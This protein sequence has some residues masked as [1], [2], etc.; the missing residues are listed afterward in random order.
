MSSDFGNGETPTGII[1]VLPAALA[2]KIA[3]GEVVQR[4]ASA[5]KELMEN[6]VD[7]GARKIRVVI[8][9]AGSSLV[10]VI[11]DG[12]GM[13][14][15]DGEM[16]FMRHATS[17][18]SSIEDL[19]RIHTLGFRGEALASIASVAQVELKTRRIDDE[20]G[21]CFRTSGGEELER[22]PCASPP[23]TS[24]A[25]RNLFFN[26]P[27]RRNFLKRPATEFKHIVEVFQYIALSKPSIGFSLTHDDRE[28]YDFT[29]AK[30]SDAFDPL[31]ER[32]AQVIGTMDM[33]GLVPVKTRT[34]YVSVSGYVGKPE[35][36]RKVRGEQ[37][38]YVNG[39]YVKHRGLLHAVSSAYG[40][41]LPKGSYPFFVLK[42]EMDPRHAD[43]NV[44]PTK[45]EVKF[46]DESGIYGF[47]RGSVN[48]A[49]GSADLRPDISFGGQDRMVER[50]Y[51]TARSTGSR[52]KADGGKEN[53]LRRYSE[54][55]RAVDLSMSLY[56][57]AAVPE[58]QDEQ[59]EIA[60]RAAGEAGPES[61]VR[62]TPEALDEHER[63]KPG[64]GLAS[65][66]WQL[67]LKYVLVRD[68]DGMMIVDQHAAHERILYE[69][70]L[71]LL[72]KGS[73]TSQQLL[74]PISIDLDPKD[75]TLLSELA[76]GLA[77]LGFT[78]DTFGGSSIILRG[79][80]DD[81][82]AG[83]EKTALEEVLEQYR[84]N[85]D[86]YQL[87]ERDNLAKSLSCKAAIKTGHRMSRAE[88]LK[89]L[90]DLES[91]EMPYACP[92]GRPTMIHVSLEELDK[93]FGRIGH[94]ER[95]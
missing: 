23:G 70:F 73:G 7:A 42:L 38:L 48:K 43:V 59:P 69:R 77:K 40:E 79:V 81:L 39:R 52:H 83:N 71:R 27:A 12:C 51:S 28:V 58:R 19:D 14:A 31:Q 89:L 36:T 80:P 53:W 72:D 66:F 85:R 67:G 88:T 56:K 20:A 91:C 62:R 61:S 32:I 54:D 44:H 86:S 1:H 37:F 33:Q 57:S 15:A 41:M 78:Y 21:V 17:K 22:S 26:V 4:P 68:T 87:T 13:S 47:V 9:G 90:A 3:A 25:V 95:E 63:R 65:E 93:R 8:G 10:Q 74:F 34:S 30:G 64:D 24:V 92:H 94:L 84:I 16:C 2:N 76:E 50:G 18:I 35:F 75:F 49:L 60:A 29:P 82:P 46:D 55:K 45:S 11:D 6:A 5:V